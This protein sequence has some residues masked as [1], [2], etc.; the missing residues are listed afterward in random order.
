MSM[1]N[2]PSVASKCMTSTA[3]L[4]SDL[5]FPQQEGTRG[6]ERREHAERH[7][8]QDDGHGDR[9]VEVRLRIDVDGDRQRLCNPGEVTGERDRRA[10]L[11]QGA[12]PCEPDGGQQHWARQR[13][14]DAFERLEP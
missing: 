7:P 13:Q 6:A 8:E 10:E 14:Y 11:A 4:P 12:R 9:L 1:W 3:R 5:P 2:D